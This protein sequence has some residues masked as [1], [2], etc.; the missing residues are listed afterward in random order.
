MDMR[1]KQ[2]LASVIEIQ[3]E[4]IHASFKDNINQQYLCRGL[5]NIKQYMAFF[6]KLELN[7]L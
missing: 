5:E 6:S 4:S 1:R 3:K 2:I 7:Y